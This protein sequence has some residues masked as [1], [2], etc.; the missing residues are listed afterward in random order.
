MYETEGWWNEQQMKLESQ[1]RTVFGVAM[2]SRIM[3]CEADRI[4]CLAIFAT[5]NF[6]VCDQLSAHVL[7]YGYLNTCRESCYEDNSA[8]ASDVNMQ[9]WPM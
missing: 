8:L 3:C 7:Q 6:K 9:D 2:W 1:G 5:L 4:E